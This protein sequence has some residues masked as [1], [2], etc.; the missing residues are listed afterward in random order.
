MGKTSNIFALKGSKSNLIRMSK[1][2][3]ESS[4]FLKRPI[5]RGKSIRKN[6]I[7][8]SSQAVNEGFYSHDKF[9]TLAQ[10]IDKKIISNILESEVYKS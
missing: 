1:G 8:A 10:I 3:L 4:N 6:S 2:W 7:R 9:V 5:R